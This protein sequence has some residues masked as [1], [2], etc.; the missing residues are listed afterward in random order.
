MSKC[1]YPAMDFIASQRIR[2]TASAV[3]LT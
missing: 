3:L 2:A 1:V